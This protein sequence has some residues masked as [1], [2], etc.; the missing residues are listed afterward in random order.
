MKTLV[1]GGVKDQFN[2]GNSMVTFDSVDLMIE[3]FVQN[4][5]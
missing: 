1:S 2:M 3:L 5:T 4:C